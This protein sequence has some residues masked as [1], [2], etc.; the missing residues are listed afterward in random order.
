[1]KPETY[2]VTLMKIGR[3]AS[4]T[5]ANVVEEYDLDI[6]HCIVLDERSATGNLVTIKH[7]H[8][9][10]DHIVTEHR[11]HPGTTKTTEK[12]AG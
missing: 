9:T 10:I 4:K 3:G 5:Y 11:P 7:R 8:A 6:Y 1:M 2:S 12:P